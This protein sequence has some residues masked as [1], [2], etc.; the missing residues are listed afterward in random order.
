MYGSVFLGI[1]CNGK[2]YTDPEELVQNNFL[3]W[4]LGVNKYWNNNA[5]RAE[6]ARFPLRIK[7]QCRTFRFWLTLANHKENNCYKLSQVAYNDMKRMKDKV[8]WSQ[9]I[10]NFLYQTGLGNLWEKKHIF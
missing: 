7:A 9:K 8:F 1:D 5:C 6:T 10:K 4:L 2:L 3:K